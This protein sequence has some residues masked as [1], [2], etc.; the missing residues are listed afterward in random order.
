MR[1]LFSLLVNV[2]SEQIFKETVEEV[3]KGDLV[4][5]ICVDNIR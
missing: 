5:G 3:E 4:N 1:L 2:Y